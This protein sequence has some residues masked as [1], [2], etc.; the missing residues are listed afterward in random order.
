M[1]KAQSVK[2]AP[3]AVQ[4]KVTV[5]PDKVEPAEGVRRAGFPLPSLLV[6]LELVLVVVV[7]VLLLEPAPVLYWTSVEP[8]VPLVYRHCRRTQTVVPLVGI[9]EAVLARVP[10]ERLP[11]S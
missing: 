1:R 2:A 9:P 4:E 11:L 7:L 3:L 8:H 10:L 5:L 6:E